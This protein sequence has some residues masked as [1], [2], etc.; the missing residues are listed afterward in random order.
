MTQPYCAIAIFSEK[1]WNTMD[2]QM[3]V[4][5][6]NRGWQKGMSRDEVTSSSEQIKHIA[7]SYTWL[8]IS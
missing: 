2:G 6:T 8:N 4:H 5:D 1:N 3:Q 7:L